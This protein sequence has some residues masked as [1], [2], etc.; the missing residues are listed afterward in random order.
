MGLEMHKVYVHPVMPTCFPPTYSSSM[1]CPV[2][3]WNGTTINPWYMYTPFVCFGGTSIPFLLIHWSNGHDRERCNAKWP[4]YIGALLNDHHIGLKKLM[5][6]I[7]LSSYTFGS[8]TSTKRQ[9]AY[10]ELQKCPRGRPAVVT[11]TVRA[12]AESVRV[13]SFSRDLLSK[14]AG[15]ARETTCSGSGPP[16]LYRWRATT[17]WTPHNRSNQVYFSF[18]L[19][20]RSSS[21]LALG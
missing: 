17:D 19:C 15:L 1:Y 20:I 8:S 2:Q 7:R 4:L 21:S 16:P 11:R 6:C 13:P 12:C 9:G 10:V 5:A 18:Y 14:T 3:I